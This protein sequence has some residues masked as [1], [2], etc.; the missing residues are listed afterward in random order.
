[1]S[2]AK[3]QKMEGK[4]R[5]GYN[6]NSMT[7]TELTPIITKMASDMETLLKEGNLDDS[8]AASANYLGN[9]IIKQN[10]GNIYTIATGVVERSKIK[11]DLLVNEN[12]E[13]IRTE[14]LREPDVLNAQ[15]NVEEYVK[16]PTM[17]YDRLVS[18]EAKNERAILHLQN[19]RNFYSVALLEQSHLLKA[20]GMILD[21]A[22]EFKP[23]SAYE[24]VTTYGDVEMFV[25]TEQRISP[26]EKAPQIRTQRPFPTSSSGTPLSRV[27]LNTEVDEDD[28]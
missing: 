24:D 10:Y 15:K 28:V 7:L 25:P 19:K 3:K 27:N 20:Y 22:K 21:K 5:G 16:I 6:G 11:I 13:V 4:G 9:D 1:M 18:A 12:K 14:M 17:T 8:I 2:A 26:S 23:K